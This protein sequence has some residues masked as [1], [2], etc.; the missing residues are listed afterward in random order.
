MPRIVYVQP[1][2]ARDECDVEA[3]INLM[4]AAAVHAIEGIVGECGGNC[5]CATCH[6]YVD[7]HQI[8]LLPARSE[9]EDALLDGVAAER[10]AN[11]RLA[12]QIN[13]QPALDGLIVRLPDRQI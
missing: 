1:D 10:R 2:G 7:P 13:M 5:M 8:D 4:Q 12:C 6:V 9:A 11:S 3:G